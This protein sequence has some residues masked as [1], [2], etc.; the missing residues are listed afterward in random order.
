MIEYLF[1]VRIHI[2]RRPHSIPSTHKHKYSNTLRENEKQNSILANAKRNNKNSID[3][4][5]NKLNPYSNHNGYHRILPLIPISSSPS[6][7]WITY[8]ETYYMGNLKFETPRVRVRA[9]E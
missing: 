7:Y 4:S 2:H 9:N 5:I 3:I 6:A 1:P 8:S